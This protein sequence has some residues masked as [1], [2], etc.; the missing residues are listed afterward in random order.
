MDRNGISEN[1]SVRGPKCYLHDQHHTATRG[2]K[3]LQE[4]TEDYTGLN[5]VTEGYKGFQGVTGECK[6]LQGVKRC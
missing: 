1:Y 3:G 5:G 4:V 2:Y 6:E